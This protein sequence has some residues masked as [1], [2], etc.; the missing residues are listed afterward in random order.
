MKKKVFIL[1]LAVMFVVAMA[2]VTAQTQKKDAKSATNT[3]VKAESKSG[4][5]SDKSG[6]KKA[7][8]SDKKADKKCCS[9]KSG[10]KKACGE[11]TANAEKK[12]CCSKS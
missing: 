9:D 10:E 1:S 4:C 7:A 3:E 8:C 6:D 5:C 12:G 2:T 11:K